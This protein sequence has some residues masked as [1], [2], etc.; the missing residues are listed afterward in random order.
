MVTLLAHGTPYSHH[1]MQSSESRL[2]TFS[3]ETKE[4]LR[5]FRLGTSRAKDPQAVICEPSH[6]LRPFPASDD[7]QKTRST[8]RTWRSSQKTATSTQICKSSPTKYQITRRDTSSSP[9]LSRCHQDGTII[10]FV[11]PLTLAYD[12]CSLSVPYVMINYLPATCNAE[13]RML[14][15]GAKELMKNTAEAGR[16]IEI[17]NAEDLE[18]IE[19][20]LKGED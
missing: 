7:V 16:I 5:K 2:Y 14:Y 20:V 6:F 15:A 13:N 19:E 11:M 10:H 8:K 18:G 12:A 17:D 3:T 1:A 4:K 9:I